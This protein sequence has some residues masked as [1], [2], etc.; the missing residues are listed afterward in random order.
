MRIETFNTN[1]P[2][3]TSSSNNVN[4]ITTA[5]PNGNIGIEDFYF[6]TDNILMYRNF[7]V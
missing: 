3:P 2:V 7:L 5:I 1:N 4:S 6:N